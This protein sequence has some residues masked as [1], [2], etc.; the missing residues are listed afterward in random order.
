[1]TPDK[2][3]YLRDWAA[4]GNEPRDPV[5]VP[6][7]YEANGFVIKDEGGDFLAL[8][9]AGLAVTELAD[10]LEQANETAEEMVDRLGPHYPM[11]RNGTLLT[12]RA[13]KRRLLG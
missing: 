9:L 11:P 10:A 12:M 4:T 13:N 2:S 7:W 1:M 8:S 6:W 3:D 5:D